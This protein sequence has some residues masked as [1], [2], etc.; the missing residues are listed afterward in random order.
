MTECQEGEGDN[1]SEGREEIC[2]HQLELENNVHRGRVTSLYTLRVI[3][4]LVLYVAKFVSRKMTPNE[5]NV[6]PFLLEV[7][8]LFVTSTACQ[9]LSV[10]K[11]C[12]DG[13]I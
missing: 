11:S 1:S 5:C 12:A 3:T 4:A 2:I 8:V 13:Y 6:D 10:L 9:I 7:Y